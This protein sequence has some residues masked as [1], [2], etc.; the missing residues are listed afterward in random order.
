MRIIH[1]KAM[2]SSLLGLAM[3]VSYA[4][5]CGCNQSKTRSNQVQH[6]PEK[7]RVPVRQERVSGSCDFGQFAPLRG[8]FDSH[9]NPNDRI[10]TP[11]YPEEARHARI[12]GR[13]TVKVLVNGEGTVER[14]CVQSGDPKLAQASE[15]AAEKSKFVP[16]LLNERPIPYV[17]RTILFNYVLSSEQP[18]LIR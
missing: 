9:P 4:A 12:E 18:E 2:E 14:V 15:E 17:E 7:S 8:D 16:L 10:V 5:C 13:V 3:L 1:H 11:I 6:G